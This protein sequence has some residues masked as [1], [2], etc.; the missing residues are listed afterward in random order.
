MILQNK[1][2]NT[3]TRY[4]SEFKG[5]NRLPVI[6]D[7]ELMS[8]ENMVFDLYPVM[9]VRPGR[10]EVGSVTGTPQGILLVDD[11]LV[12]VAGGTLYM[13]GV[14]SSLTGLSAG[15][16]SM[17]EFWGKI[18]VFPDKKYYDI[19]SGESGNMGTGTFP[20]DGSVPDMDYVCVHNNRIWGVKGNFIYASASGW[21]MGAASEAEIQGWVPVY[22]AQ[23]YPNDLGACWFEVASEGSFSGI[24]SWDDKIVALKKHCHHEITGTYPSNFALSTVS[25]CGTAAHSSIQEVDG[26]LIFVS[27]S[28][29]LTYGGSF[30]NNISRNLNEDFGTA[31]IYSAG[32]DGIR[33]YLSGKFNGIDKLYVYDT[34]VG[35][36][37]E[38][39]PLSVV[40]F[41]KGDG[42]LLAL[43]FDGS[44]LRMRSAESEEDISWSF[45]FS[46]YADSIF[47]ESK[48]TKM[49]LKIKGEADASLKVEMSVESKPFETLKECTF[50]GGFMQTIKC[51]MKRG[52][53]HIFLISGKGK[54]DIYGYQ[55][56]AQSGGEHIV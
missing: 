50:D 33:Y 38:E 4:T 15:V 24:S 5:L 49:I 20:E 13:D 36:W 56:V 2:M 40:Q 3:Y 47:N 41:A 42:C 26:R 9:T 34:F 46:D 39:D 27:D 43:C 7:G 51:D 35:V 19:E 52:T 31:E 12:T 30:E 16:K 32:S 1:K 44:I 22:D 37:T 8:S 23:G 54:V 45:S 10:S 21:A 29:V 48:V 53:E 55:F 18:F 17:V 28:G 6:D 25:K 14:A 11:A